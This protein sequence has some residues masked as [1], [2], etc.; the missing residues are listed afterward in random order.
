MAKKLSGLT[1][2]GKKT[3]KTGRS[4]VK[5]GNTLLKRNFGKRGTVKL[6]AQKGLSQIRGKKILGGVDEKVKPLT[7]DTKI[8]PKSKISKIVKNI[9]NNIVPSLEKKVEGRIDSFDPNKLLGKIFDGGLGELDGFGAALSKMQREQL[10]FLER[11]NKLAVDFVSKLASGKGG[12]GFLR[13]VGNI[14]KVIAAAGVAAIAAPFVLTGLAAAGIV[15]GAK[16]VGSKIIDGVKSVGKF[17]KRKGKEVKDKVK[18]KASKFFA[19]SLD[20][21]EGI[22]TFLEKRGEPKEEVQP[23][24]GEGK[25]ETSVKPKETPMGVGKENAT[26]EITDDG[27]FVVTRTPTTV[28]EEE[29]VEENK[30]KG[31]MR[32]VT[33]IADH[34]TGG[35]FDF[36]KRGD[37]KLQDLGQGFVDNMTLGKTDFDEKGRSPVQNVIQNV[38]GLVKKGLTGRDGEKGQTGATGDRGLTGKDILSRV[39]GIADQASQFVFGSDFSDFTK[40]LLNSASSVI[41]GGPVK[42]EEIQT[43]DDLQVEQL[44]IPEEVTTSKVESNLES[45]NQRQLV[46][47]DVSQTATKPGEPQIVPLQMSGDGG[48]TQA[49]TPTQKQT[50]KEMTQAGN[51]IP[52]LSSVDS[53]NI[54]LPSTM[55]MLNIVDA[56]NGN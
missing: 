26:I 47:D 52:I 7:K 30:P 23:P 54:H 42:A 17:F 35:I 9:T 45:L 39:S 12:G 3:L 4:I 55:S 19:K 1:N 50:I 15:A 21:L 5:K 51:N 20:K 28:E 37:T 40:G 27:K 41:L 16:F 46:A 14:I 34:F 33:G 11:A 36:D 10:P 32:A 29:E 43:P 38:F 49:Q 22:M 13:T 25:K 24:D 8:S 44:N 56:H 31:L 53:R 2:L 6:K 18:T 48:T